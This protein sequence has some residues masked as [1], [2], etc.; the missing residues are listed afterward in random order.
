MRLKIL[1]KRLRNKQDSFF[2][3]GDIAIAYANDGT[4][5]L[6]IAC[7]EIRLDIK[8]KKY[9]N[10]FIRN[11]SV[12]KWTRILK[13]GDKKLERYLENGTAEWHNNNWF[14]IIWLN[15]DGNWDFDIGMVE[16]EYD[17][18]IQ[19]LR[20]YVHEYNGQNRTKPS[21]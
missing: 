19:M 20:D 17:S 13:L 5:F 18:G 11:S 8:S 21:G 2:Y 1:E 15:E 14:E 12:D 10:I 16:H 9:G 6:L 4:K 3:G 7:G